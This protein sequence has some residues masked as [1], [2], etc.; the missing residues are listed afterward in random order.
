M[1][2]ELQELYLQ[3]KKNIFEIN[4]RMGLMIL[5]EL[6][7]IF[8]NPKEI[9]SIYIERWWSQIIITTYDV[10]ITIDLPN[11]VVTL[12]IEDKYI[13]S[14]LLFITELETILLYL[15]EESFSIANTFIKDTCLTH[16]AKQYILLLHTKQ[17][18]FSTI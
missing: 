11:E 18:Q 10:N 9:Q 12:F 4:K 13:T 14:R 6:D 1:D 2:Q 8:K 15:N 16:L 7:T 3:G 17:F 5:E